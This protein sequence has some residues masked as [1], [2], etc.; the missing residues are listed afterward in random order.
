M[1]T[2]YFPS[3]LQSGAIL[4]PGLDVSCSSGCPL[5]TSLRKSCQTPVRNE[6]NA[7]SRPLGDQVGLRSGLGSNVWRV[8][9]RRAKSHVQISMLPDPSASSI[10]AREPSGDTRT[11]V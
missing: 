10:A 4:S 2:R 8:L 9:I 11:C 7:I 5:V 1:K 6:E 3:R